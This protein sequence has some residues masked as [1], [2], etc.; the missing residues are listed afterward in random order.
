MTE[1][2]LLAGD[3]GGTNTRLGFFTADKGLFSPQHLKVFKNRDY[4]DLDQLLDEYLLEVDLEL[5]GI[6]LGIAGPVADNQVQLTNL[7]WEISGSGL[8]DRH[9]LH[10]VWLLNDIEA[11][12]YSVPILRPED[13]AVIRK[14]L[15]QAG[16]PIAVIAPGTGLG[17]GYLVQVDGLYHAI[18]TEGGHT[19]FGPTNRQQDDLVRYLHEKGMRIS[20]EKVCSGV[21]IPNLYNFLLDSG[22]ADET[23]FIQEKLKGIE[24]PVPV[25]FGIGLDEDLGCAICRQVVD[26]FVDILGAEAGNLAVKTLAKGGVFLGGGI[27]PRI[28]P[29]LQNGRFLKAFDNKSP[30]EGLM[31]EIPIKVIVNPAANLIGAAH[32]GFRQLNGI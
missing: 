14:G 13:L 17:E 32:Y 28:L 29:R 19:D 26:L 23:A 25:I 2:I 1:R 18:S 12:S 21:G 8:R 5:A 15:P 31:A 11:L 4:K 16:S 3:L 10:G 20:Y 7:N 9:D 24:D 22:S 30:H 27:P 6:C